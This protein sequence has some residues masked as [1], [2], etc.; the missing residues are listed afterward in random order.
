MTGD[1]RTL[2]GFGNEHESE[3]Q[4]GVLPTRGN[5]PQRPAGGLVTE[6]LSGTAFT[7]PRATNRRT[8]LYRRR[9]SVQHVRQLQPTTYP[10]F[11][12]AP[13]PNPAWLAQSRW[14][15]DEPTAAAADTWLAGITTV[16]TNGNAHLHVGGAIHTYGFGASTELAPVFV[17]TDAE[18]LFVPQLGRVELQTELGPL[19]VEPGHIGVVPRGI[20]VRVSTAAKL[21]SG[22]LHENY[23]QAFT[24]PDPGITGPNTSA[25]ARDFVYPSAQPEDDAPTAIIVKTGGRFLATSID[26]TPLDVVAWRGNY[27]PYRYDLRQFSPLGAV[28]FDHPDPSLGT[29]LTSPSDLV[30]TANVDLVVFRE[31]WVVAEDTFR[32]PWFHSNTM[33]EFMGLIDGSYDAKPGQAPGSMTLHNQ[34]L[35][36]GPATTAFEAASAA[37]LM[38][39]RL[40]PTL[41]FMLESRYVWQPTQWAA[42]TDRLDVDY[43]ACWMPST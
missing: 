11:V 16:V 20:K 10:Q 14:N 2:S 33:S 40:E 3:S 13:D 30:G 29:V 12:T 31:R 42:T 43:D 22:W 35:P 27:A 38:P 23:G 6:Q 24:L 37:E 9:P 34:H 25:L 15:P 41:A 26:R 28:L 18:M 5:S 8:W 19:A 4:A 39:Q 21:A 7:A 1:P 32:P 17:N 36:H